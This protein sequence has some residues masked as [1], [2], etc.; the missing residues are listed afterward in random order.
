MRK[1]IEKTSD[2]CSFTGHVYNTSIAYDSGDLYSSPTHDEYEEIALLEVMAP[3]SRSTSA[4]SRRSRSWRKASTALRG[5]GVS[6][7]SPTGCVTPDCT[8][9]YGRTRHDG[10]GP[11]AL[12]NV[13]RWLT[14]F[15]AELA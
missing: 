3:T 6:T 4:T 13:G 9:G 15:H 1:W 11:F 7:R 8:R 2:N 12:E 5:N 14:S 10:S